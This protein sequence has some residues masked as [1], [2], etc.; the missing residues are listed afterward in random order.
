MIYMVALAPVLIAVIAIVT[1]AVA[2][3]GKRGRVT[4]NTIESGINCCTMPMNS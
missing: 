2:S 4:V 3:V 1:V